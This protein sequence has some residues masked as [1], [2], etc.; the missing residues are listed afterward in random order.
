MAHNDKS[1]QLNFKIPSTQPILSG[2]N[3][4]LRPWKPE[5]ATQLAKICRN[6]EIA[7]YTAVPENYTLE[8]GKEF[9]ADSIAGYPNNAIRYCITDVENE[10]VGSISLER[11]SLL[12]CRA[13]IGYL[14]AE[15]HRGKGIAVEATRILTSI[16]HQWG[17]SRVELLTAV[18]NL[19]S[20]KVAEKSGF[21]FEG[22]LRKRNIVKGRIFDMVIFSSIAH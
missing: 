22:V 4:V 2:E 20:Q 12:D 15:G 9:I 17:F 6:P 1:Q 11:L 10:I 19:A 21:T 13:E 3:L 16:V 14:V 7:R 18:E 5:D 8:M